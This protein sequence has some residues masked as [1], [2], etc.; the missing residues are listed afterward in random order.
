MYAL[1]DAPFNL[2]YKSELFERLIVSN[3]PQI[4]GHLAPPRSANQYLTYECR[5]IAEL[6]GIYEDFS[7]PEVRWG[8]QL[9]LA[10]FLGS[11]QNGRV[12]EETINSLPNNIVYC[13]DLISGG[14]IN[15][16]NYKELC[17]KTLQNYPNVEL[18]ID[19]VLRG[20]INRPNRMHISRQRMIMGAGTVAISL[21]KSWD[22][23]G[24]QTREAIEVSNQAANATD[25]DDELARLI[26]NC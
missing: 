7:T 16:S 6:T 2:D 17:E 4:E 20:M 21:G 3:D 11:D 13:I 8:G 5:Q 1:P 26:E 14:C 9:V 22:K 15:S 18:M 25:F 19:E 24:Q 12:I 10:A 23:L